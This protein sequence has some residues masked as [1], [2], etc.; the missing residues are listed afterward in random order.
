MRIAPNAKCQRVLELALWFAASVSRAEILKISGQY[1]YHTVSLYVRAVSEY[2]NFGRPKDVSKYR[3]LSRRIHIA[4]TESS[5]LNKFCKLPV[6]SV[7]FY[8]VT[9]V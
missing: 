3:I 8:S 5:E 9:T 2:E 4:G 6:R 7:Q 1:L